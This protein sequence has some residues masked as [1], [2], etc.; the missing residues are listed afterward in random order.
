MTHWTLNHR[1]EIDRL[2]ALDY[3]DR[4]EFAFRLIL[5]ASS[6]VIHMSYTNMT[7]ALIWLQGFIAA[8]LLYFVVLTTRPAEATARDTLLAGLI[9]LVLLCA[10]I[11]FP[12]YMIAQDDM[13]VR[14]SGIAGIGAL[15]MFLI[16]RSD[17]MKW[18]VLSEIAL[19]TLAVSFVLL[20]EMQA[21][22]DVGA[23]L[24]TGFAGVTLISYFTRTI[25]DHRLR[26][27]AAEAAANRSVQAQRMEAVGQLAGGVAHDFNNI[28]TAVTGNLDLYDAVQDPEERRQFI[29]EARQSADRAAGL[30]GQ[31]LAYSRKTTLTVA[32]HDMSEVFARI[33]V[34]SRGLLPSSVALHITP[35]TEPLLVRVDQNQLITAMIN[36]MINARDALA[37]A[38]HL[39]IS[40]TPERLDHATPMLD[41]ALLEAGC[42]VR[43]AICDDGPG[44]PRDI[45][46]RV[47]EPFF[48]TKGIGEG[49]GLGLSMVEGFARQSHGGLT[50]TTSPDGTEAM[51]WLPCARQLAARV[52][53]D[54]SLAGLRAVAAQRM[55]S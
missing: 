33:N 26:R 17:T 2:Y 24:V 46:R 9:F 25:L 43:I 4:I 36:L 31:L 5:S 30:V 38:G 11:W 16:Q 49:S 54:Q 23:R 28:L 7:L 42:Y 37:G 55:P 12:V 21:M 27:L 8:H 48:T 14:M 20:R 53:D 44:I 52:A 6:A 18:M 45:L 13:A 32:D 51:L 41:G 3:G 22:Q 39:S 34:L 10:F 50:I 47:T 15:L 29:A 40:A 19:V 35:P 1:K